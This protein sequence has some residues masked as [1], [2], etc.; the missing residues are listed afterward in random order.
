MTKEKGFDKKGTL[1]NASSIDKMHQRI[2]TLILLLV[3][4]FI[5]NFGFLW[6]I[7]FGGNC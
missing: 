2:E 4:S 5:C 3:L 1:L 6:I 7:F